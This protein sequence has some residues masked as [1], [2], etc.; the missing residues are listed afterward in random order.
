MTLIIIILVT[1]A[2]ASATGFALGRSGRAPRPERKLLAQHVQFVSHINH[3]AAQHA[4][5]EPFAV[6]VMDEVNTF[7]TNQNRSIK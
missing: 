3:L 4:Q 6:I 2:C 5:S 7:T 1:A